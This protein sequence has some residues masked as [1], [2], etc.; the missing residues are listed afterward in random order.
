MSDT[1]YMYMYMHHWI[2]QINTLFIPLTD[3]SIAQL[4]S[5][6]I[7]YILLRKNIEMNKDFPSHSSPTQAN[8]TDNNVS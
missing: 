1:K 2:E 7:K 3:V 8:N 5:R 4:S 6:E